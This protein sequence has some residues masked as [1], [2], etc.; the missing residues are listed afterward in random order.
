MVIA[1][2]AVGLFVL[3]G[4]IVW[5]L[6]RAAHNPYGEEVALLRSFPKKARNNDEDETETFG[7]WTPAQSEKQRT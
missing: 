5:F 7:E 6:Y 2:V 3:E 4:S 1:A